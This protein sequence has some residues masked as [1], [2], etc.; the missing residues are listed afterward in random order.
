M[1]RAANHEL[2]CPVCG[3]AGLEIPP[4]MGEICPCCGTEFGYSDFTRTHAQLRSRW[5]LENQA[6]WWSNYDNPP[7]GWHPLAQ[8]LGSGLEVSDLEA[9]AISAVHGPVQGASISNRA[10]AAGAKN[11]TAPSVNGHVAGIAAKVRVA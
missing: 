6:R 1:N 5:V 4:S 11:G 2:T 7:P 10:G 8:L 9:A 3:Y